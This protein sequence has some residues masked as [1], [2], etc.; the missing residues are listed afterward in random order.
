M[1]LS[2]EDDEP[3][4]SLVTVY[5]Y[6][7]DGENY[8]AF[9]EDSVVK[10]VYSLGTQTEFAYEDS[11][12][13]LKIS[14]KLQIPGAIPDDAE[15]VVAQITNDTDGYNYE[16]YMDALND[17]A[18]SIADDAGLDEANTYTDSN[19]LMYDIAFMYEGEEVQ[20]AEGAVYG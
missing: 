12:L 3:E 8:T 14:A 5:S 20:P 16:A 17:N 19:T 13:G 9:D 11:D 18:D 15:L 7:T 10:F 4:L 6:T 1:A 2:D